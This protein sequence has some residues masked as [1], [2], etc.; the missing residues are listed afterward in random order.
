[1]K[2]L[3][4]DGTE[5]DA[6][7]SVSGTTYHG[8]PARQAVVRDVTERK[9][10]EE[11]LQRARDELETRV[12]RRMERA[13]HYSLTFRELTVSTWLG[14]ADRIAMQTGISLGR[15]GKHV[16]HTRR[17]APSRTEAGVRAIQEGLVESL[18]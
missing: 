4:K 3:R 5:F 13:G 1:M 18:G 12:E 8:R 6:E 15:L 17:W 7:V 16:E 10:A 9:R 2:G 14:A 11:A